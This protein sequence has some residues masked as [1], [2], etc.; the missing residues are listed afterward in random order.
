MLLHHE[1]YT[2]EGEK[3]R[4]VSLFCLFSNKKSVMFGD[5]SGQVLKKAT[6]I[7]N[8]TEFKIGHK[9]LKWNVLVGC[10]YENR[11]PYGFRARSTS[12]VS[13]KILAVQMSYLR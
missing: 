7:L 9:L 6:E 4:I 10:W 2:Q 3:D 1:K 5:T 8:G 11:E 12:N 13:R